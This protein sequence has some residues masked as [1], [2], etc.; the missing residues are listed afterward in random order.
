MYITP[1]ITKEFW[2][3]Y[4]NWSL[5]E[6]LMVCPKKTF[7]D[8]IYIY[9]YRWVQVTLDATLKNTF[10]KLLDL[11]KSNGKK[12]QSLMLIFWLI[13]FIIPYLCHS[14]FISKPKK[15]VYVSPSL[16]HCSRVP[17]LRPG[18]RHQKK[19]QPHTY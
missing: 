16:L 12:I 11:S 1:K 19:P 17:P 4:L 15:N 9:I 13:S 6:S 7:R 3:W 2:I 18:C 5:N 10:S 14:I 8:H